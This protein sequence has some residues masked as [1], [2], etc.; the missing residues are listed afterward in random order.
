MHMPKIDDL[1]APA[2][3]SRAAIPDIFA[4][5]WLDAFSSG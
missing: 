3:L 5:Y 4:P 2:G 1:T